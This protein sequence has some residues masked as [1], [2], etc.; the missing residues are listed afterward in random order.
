MDTVAL[1]RTQVTVAG[2]VNVSSIFRNSQMKHFTY[3]LD[4]KKLSQHN[5]DDNLNDKFNEYV[6]IQS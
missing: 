3:G 6:S 5:Q 4:F 2:W 1:Q